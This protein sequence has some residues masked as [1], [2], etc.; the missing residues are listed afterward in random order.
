MKSRHD[1][2]VRSQAAADDLTR[3]DPAEQLRIDCRRGGALLIR[4]SQLD[5]LIEQ[6][7]ELAGKGAS[8]VTLSSRDEVLAALGLSPK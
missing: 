3:V 2:L 8:W 7:I 4:G 1:D 5:E 6:G